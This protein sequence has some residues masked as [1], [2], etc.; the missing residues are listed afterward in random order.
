MTY[1]KCP[2]TGEPATRHVQFVKARFL[3]SA[4]K[5]VFG[6]PTRPS[7]GDVE[8]FGLWESPTGLYF[9]DPMI[10]GDQ[11]FYAKFHARLIEAGLWSPNSIRTEF[12]IAARRIAPGQRVL[13][14]GCGFASFRAV[15]PYADYVG[16]DPNLPADN[17]AAG[18]FKQTLQDH[19]REHA[20]AYD[21]VCSFQVIEH[22]ASPTHFFSEMVR[23]ARPGGL[24]IVGVPHIPS[25]LTRIPN[26]LLN[27][28]P[29]H[30]TWWTPKAL[31]IL[32]EQ[33][34]TVVESIEVIPWGKDNALLYWMERCS[35]IRCR[36]IHYRNVLSW[37]AAALVSYL[38]GHLIKKLR[39]VPETTD[40]GSG[41]L[42]IARRPS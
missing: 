5:L 24:V 9:F 17:R 29:H 19:L 7:F 38:G 23:A 33:H 28:P 35:P 12:E 15:I 32:S 39:G 3:V 4:W 41:L 27:A 25:A 22:V 36:D 21:V 34:A 30:L 10:E 37:H 26:F 14:V 42:L 13:D 1:P 6:V 2:I 8:R 11:E 16:L 18:I 20:E 40:E 31:E